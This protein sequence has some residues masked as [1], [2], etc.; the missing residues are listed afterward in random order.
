MLGWFGLPEGASPGTADRILEA[1]VR[2]LSGEGLRLAGAVQV[3]LDRGQNCACDMDIVVIGEESRPIR[4][5]QSLGT[6]STGCRLDPGALEM[7]AAR[8]AAGLA[9]AELLVLPKFGKQEAIGRGFCDVIGQAV[10]SGLPVLLHVPHDQRQAF[11]AFSGALAEE[12]RP[13]ALADWCRKQL[14]GAT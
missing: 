8:V 5:S 1:L 2:E 12:V 9:G 7:A 6:G 13:D 14:A 3:N 10:L 11:A 4:I